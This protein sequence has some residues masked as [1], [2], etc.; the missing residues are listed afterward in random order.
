M[1]AG[2]SGVLLAAIGVSLSCFAIVQYTA[3]PKVIDFTVVAWL[4]LFAIMC[5]IVPSVSGVSAPPD[6]KKR[7]C[8]RHLERIVTA[9]LKYHAV[10]GAFPPAY[11][12]DENGMPMH[13][14]RVLLL[15]F[16]MGG[17]EP[18]ELYDFN[19]PWNGPNNIK[20][21][22]LRPP[23]YVCP[24]DCCVSQGNTSYLAVI[25][26]LAAWR[27]DVPVRAND[28][29][30]RLA[31]TIVLVEVA[32]SGIR[33]SE[34]RDLSFRQLAL[35][36]NHKQGNG[37][38]SNHLVGVGL[39]HYESGAWVAFG[40]SS[41]QFLPSDLNPRMLESFAAAGSNKVVSRTI[42]RAER[43]DWI[44]CAAMVVV[45]VVFPITVTGL[46]VLMRRREA[47]RSQI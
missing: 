17:R 4:T 28:F 25:G 35:G 27:S 38:A 45:S 39:T 13:S 3:W 34:P 30:D 10:H 46:V 26:E 9:L 7:S 37:I 32:E 36:I 42:L 41:V 44:K 21:V 14:W 22:S 33:W 16:I 8:G 29:H 47:L 1:T 15:P 11:I 6:V 2:A 43:V 19:E 5:L 20:I 40:N 31:N 12:T 23:W 18:L 24:S